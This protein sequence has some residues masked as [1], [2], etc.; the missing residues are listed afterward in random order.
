VQALLGVHGACPPTPAMGA[1]MLA[2]AA[3][4]MHDIPTAPVLA[5]KQSCVR[6]Q[7][8]ADTM[9]DMGHA[10]VAQRLRSLTRCAAAIFGCTCCNVLLPCVCLPADVS[11]CACSMRLLSCIWCYTW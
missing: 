9:P 5:S 8:F 6:T 4:N 3:V 1:W 10:K 11:S 7:Y 2:V